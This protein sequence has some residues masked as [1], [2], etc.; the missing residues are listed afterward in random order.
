M[1]KK[2]QTEDQVEPTARVTLTLTL[3]PAL[4]TDELSEFDRRA[5]EAGESTAGRVARL[6][7]ED[8]EKEPVAA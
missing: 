1:S 5:R 6:I 3:S 8:L 7:R 2:L 4:S